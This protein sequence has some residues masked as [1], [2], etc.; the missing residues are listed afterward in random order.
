MIPA[1]GT[2]FDV[3]IVGGGPAGSAAA[4]SLAQSCRRVLIVEKGSQETFKVGESL[5]PGALS[6]LR[7]L[8]VQ[9]RFAAAGHLSSYGNQSAWGSDQLY[10][11]DFIRDPNGNG[12][13]LN[14]AVF[15]STLR[16]VARESGA[17]VAVRTRLIDAER[18]RAGGWR[19]L[20]SRGECLQSIKAKWVID[21]TGRR[22]W[23]AR[24]EGVG[25][26]S[27][28]RLIAFV[29]LFAR[30]DIPA[31]EPDLD[32]LTLI[33]SVKDGWWYTSLIP[34]GR[35]VV[36]FFTDADTLPAKRARETR[37]FLNLLSETVH[38]RERLGNLRYKICSS[39][40]PISADTGR[41]ERVVGDRWLAAGDSCVSFDPLSSQ[42]ILNALYSGLKAANALNSHL[43]G[44]ADALRG[45]SDNVT[46]VWDAYL[47]NRFLFYSYERRWPRSSFWKTRHG[48][49]Y[50]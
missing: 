15:D 13:H 10:S 50:S 2:H 34:A 29:S 25:R 12:W 48:T 47:K 33:E 35:R 32:S 3:T 42:G 44:D 16:D 8:R 24:R 40:A 19:L 9:E 23:F 17:E 6:L 18:D 4:I 30:D 27:H 46:A 21:C 14:R 11:T 36:V 26:E 31:L 22:S 7:E 28:D 49:S 43:D 1:P 37:G 41:L 38:I 5:P 39:P 20:L 45:Y